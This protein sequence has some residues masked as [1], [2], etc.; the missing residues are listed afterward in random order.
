[1]AVNNIDLEE[2]KDI[3]DM[4]NNSVKE[5]INSFTDTG[6]INKTEGFE[7]WVK[8]M[9]TAMNASLSAVVSLESKETDADRRVKDAQVEFTKRQTEGFDDNKKQ[10]MLDIQM[11]A[12]AM[13]FSSGL[14]SEVPNIITA[15]KVTN[16]YCMLEDEIG[17]PDSGNICDQCSDSYDPELCEAVNNCNAIEGCHFDW[18][19]MTCVHDTDGSPCT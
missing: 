15:D 13:M 2:V 14:L 7:A 17:M 11:N 1:M 10:K 8:L 12:W 18:D 4:F 5:D 16:L 9:G 3:Y 6:T 19:T